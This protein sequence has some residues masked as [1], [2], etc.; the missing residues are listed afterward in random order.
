MQ[1][2]QQQPIQPQQQQQQKYYMS[3]GDWKI[4]LKK[5]YSNGGFMRCMW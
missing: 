1:Q 2:P 5:A 4:L 3:N